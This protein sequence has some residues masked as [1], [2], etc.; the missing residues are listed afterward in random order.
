MYATHPSRQRTC[1]RPVRVHTRERTPC[2]C[3]YCSE[4]GAVPHRPG[5]PGGHLPE[6]CRACRTTEPQPA[7]SAAPAS[8]AAT[9]GTCGRSCAAA[10]RSNLGHRQGR[11]EATGGCACTLGVHSDVRRAGGAAYMRTV[12]VLRRIGAVLCVACCALCV[13]CVHTCCAC[14]SRRPSC[15]RPSTASS[16]SSTPSATGVRVCARA[17][18]R[19]P[20]RGPQ[21]APVRA[22]WPHRRRA[23]RRYRRQRRQ[24]AHH[25][26][27]ELSTSL[28]VRPCTPLAADTPVPPLPSSL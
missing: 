6:P 3:T 26:G 18:V 8:L 16:T 23:D 20:C 17:C 19:A 10:H 2:R 21:V 11:A 22:A 5:L 7:Q 13:V 27:G 15:S 14:G 28:P 24:V 25:S 9:R 4:Y 1:R 12:A